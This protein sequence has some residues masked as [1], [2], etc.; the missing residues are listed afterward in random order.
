MV[1]VTTNTRSSSN[2]RRCG[3]SG[4]SSNKTAPTRPILLTDIRVIRLRARV[5]RSSNKTF[6]LRARRPRRRATTGPER[7][8]SNSDTHT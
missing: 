6:H 2:T 8:N 5:T 4:N 1:K 3:D 7:R